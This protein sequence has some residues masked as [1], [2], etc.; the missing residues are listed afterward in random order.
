M[1]TLFERVREQG[2]RT[3]A[4]PIHEPW[5]DIGHADDYRSAQEGFRG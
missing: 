4:Y 2:G 1:P 5:L 3:I